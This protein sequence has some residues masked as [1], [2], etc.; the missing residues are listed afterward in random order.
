[1][2]AASF[3]LVTAFRWF[4]TIFI[5]TAGGPAHATTNLNVYAYLA[6]FRFYKIGYASAMSVVVLMLVL[7]FTF[8]LLRYSGA[9]IE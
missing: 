1:M 8:F 2:I 5:M 6:G 3:R 9:D 7:F 4:D